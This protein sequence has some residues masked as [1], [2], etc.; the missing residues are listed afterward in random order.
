MK[1][2]YAEALKVYLRKSISGKDHEEIVLNALKKA[3]DEGVLV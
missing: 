1:K 2:R 3:K